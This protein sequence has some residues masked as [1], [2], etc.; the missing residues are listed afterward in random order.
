MAFG[1]GAQLVRRS[2]ATWPLEAGSA[3]EGAGPTPDKSRRGRE[4]RTCSKTT[5]RVSVG[6]F[7]R[8]RF[9][10]SPCVASAL[11]SA[12]RASEDKHVDVQVKK[13]EV[14]IG[15]SKNRLANLEKEGTGHVMPPQHGCSSDAAT[16]ICSS[17]D[18]SGGRDQA[19]ARTG[20]RVGRDQH[21]TGAS[22]R[23]PTV[24][25]SGGGGFIPLMLS[26][27]PAELHQ[28]MEDRQTDLQE[29]LAE[30]NSALVFELTSKMAEVAEQLREIT[31]SRCSHE[32]GFPSNCPPVRAVRLPGG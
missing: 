7:G 29:A 19:F 16:S 13:C 28:W 22:S 15:K 12:Q 3:I 27:I 20:G 6:R 17:S 5:V 31:C 21:D 26:L 30:G 25:V 14:F 11:K 2:A 18:R 4:G 9:C 8:V 23:A 1:K 32:V 10:R 24:S